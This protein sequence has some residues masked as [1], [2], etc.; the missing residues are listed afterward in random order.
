MQSTIKGASILI[1]GANGGIG[2]E[3]VKLLIEEGAARIVLATRTQEKAEWAYSQLVS[4]M[5][6]HL[7]PQGGFDMNDAD[8]IR[9]AVDDLPSD[10]P[11]DIVFLQS[12]G[13][14]VG[15]AFQFVEANGHSIE[16]TVHQNTIG[17]YLTLKYLE[18][19]QLIKQDARI[20][21]AGGEGARGISGL[22][23]KPH[24]YSAE[25]FLSYL[26]EGREGY[27]AINAIGVSK[28]ASALLVQKLA[29]LRSDREYVWFSPGLTG[30]TKGLDG[31]P[32]P[33]RFLT[34]HI[35]FP[36]MQ[37]I[38]LAQ[39]PKQAARKYVEA[40]AGTYGQNGDLIG[41]PEGK[42][43]GKLVD[44][45]AMNP[46]LTDPFLQEAFWQLISNAYGPIAYPTQLST[47]NI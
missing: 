4:D 19:R 34:K 16:R 13:M 3:T 29:S 14:V 17:A 44:Q 46:S 41:A 6:T 32:N 26:S 43:L 39:G 12:G 9:Q 10:K 23:E 22:I 36:L 5:P 20:V 42:A 40:L 30:G 47:S 27:K 2:I 24:F 33:Q 8:R 35:G 11:F 18:E 7:E 38:G 25:D 31:L 37:F 28:L 1:T 45:K 21:F 15:D